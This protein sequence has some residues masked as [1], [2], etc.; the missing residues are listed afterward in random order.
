MSIVG[1][2]SKNF[3]SANSLSN[4][5][6]KRI[7]KVI[8]EINDSMTRVAAEK[9][10]QKEAIESLAEELSLDKKVLRKM[11]RI[12]FKAAYNTEKEDVRSFEEFY[13]LIINATVE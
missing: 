3:V 6:R 13:E 5:D 11:A 8:H 4:A 1:H 9:D 12:Y 10:L 7:K 2:N